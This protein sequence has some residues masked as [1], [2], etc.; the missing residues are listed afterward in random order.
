VVIETVGELRLV[1]QRPFGY[2]FSWLREAATGAVEGDLGL[3]IDAAGEV[4]MALAM[5]GSYRQK[6]SGVS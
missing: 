2:A 6:I 4:S 3:A 5:T 1:E